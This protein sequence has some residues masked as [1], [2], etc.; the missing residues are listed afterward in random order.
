MAEI[1]AIPGW[2][3]HILTGFGAP[4]TEKS[5][6]RWPAC[7]SE[8]YISAGWLAG[9]KWFGCYARQGSASI[10]T[11][12]VKLPETCLPSRLSQ[13]YPRGRGSRCGSDAHGGTL[14]PQLEGGE[15]PYMSDN[16]PGYDCGDIAAGDP[17]T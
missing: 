14:E 13:Y 12:S 9:K 7:G 5:C 1:A 6:A 16:S 4:M 8:R 15:Y 11:S 17:R 3:L 10:R 2:E